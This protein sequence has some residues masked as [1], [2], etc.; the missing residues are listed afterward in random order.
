MNNDEEKVRRPLN[1]GGRYQLQ[2]A[3]TIIQGLI[4]TLLGWGAS[5]MQG[6]RIDQKEMM[7]Q[8]AQHVVD[9]AIHHAMLNK[10]GERIRHNDRRLMVLEG[11]GTV[12]VP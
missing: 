7:Q 1:G 3:T 8:F 9:P 4:L 10:H 6:I 11:I 12:R 2:V 5:T